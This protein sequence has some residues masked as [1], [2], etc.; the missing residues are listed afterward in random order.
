MQTRLP[1]GTPRQ[2]G[3]TGRNSPPSDRHRYG[4]LPPAAA[5]GQ[6]SAVPPPFFPY[7]ILLPLAPLLNTPYFFLFCFEDT[8]ITRPAMFGVNVLSTLLFCIPL[9]AAIQNVSRA[10]RFLYT[11]DGNRFYIK[12][13]AYQGQGEF[14]KLSRIYTYHG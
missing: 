10:G 13:I 12:G 14:V 5:R 3:Q 7:H 11:A 9:A 6:E 8:P 4:G 2:Q 1:R